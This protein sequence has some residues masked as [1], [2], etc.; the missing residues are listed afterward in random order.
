MIQKNH[1]IFM[2]EIYYNEGGV[3]IIFLMKCLKICI[4]NSSIFLNPSSLFKLISILGYEIIFFE[5]LCLKT[6]HE[7]MKIKKNK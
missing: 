7:I 1:L 3:T 4:S 5:A 2:N 6:K